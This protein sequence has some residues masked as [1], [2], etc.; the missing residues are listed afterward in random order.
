MK[1]KNKLSGAIGFSG[2]F[3]THGMGE[4]IVGFKED[5]MDS[6]FIKNYD[7]FLEKSGYWKDMSE[8]FRNNDLII[9]NYNTIFFEPKSDEDRARG[10]V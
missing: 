2:S 7:V 10:Y 3:N 8:V 9:D 4:I 6:D 1:I 5:G